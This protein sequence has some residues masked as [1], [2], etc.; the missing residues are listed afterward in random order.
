MRNPS[1]TNCDALWN[2][3]VEYKKAFG[4]KFDLVPISI[5]PDNSFRH[6]GLVRD[7]KSGCE[8]HRL[9][10]EFDACRCYACDEQ[11]QFISEDGTVLSNIDYRLTLADG[12]DE[13]GTTDDHG[14]TIRIRT[15]QPLAIKKVEFF[16][17]TDTDLCCSKV[18][19]GRGAPIVTRSLQ[20]VT[21]SE[22]N[23]GESVKTVTINANAR[24]LTRGEIDIAWV[25]F[26][27]AIDYAKVK[28][29]AERY[30]PFGL[31][32]KNVAMTPN[33]EMYFDE[34]AFKDDFSSPHDIDMQMWFMHEMVHVWQYQLG[35][36]VRLRGAIRMGLN[37]DYTL[38]PGKRLSSYNMEAQGNI[39]SDFFALKFRSAPHA[40]YEAKY[41][42]APDA[43]V[44]Y[45]SVL[46][47]FLANPKSPTH[48]PQ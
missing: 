19:D 43:R 22:Q 25:I 8:A 45:E 48:L 44:L 16:A 35:Y 33:G 11:L 14:C 41:R 18:L 31:Q 9:L 27:D 5:G 6:F 36:P 28:V 1:T 3:I 10:G 2:I 39:L 42:N 40:L 34:S 37:Y 12:V 17:P 26:R 38:S 32:A 4:D 30:L 7:A 47:D 15:K 13:R 23:Y 21:T 20:D 46:Q 24:A 29:H